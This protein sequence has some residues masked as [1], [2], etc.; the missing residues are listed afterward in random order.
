VTQTAEK[1]LVV[2]TTPQMEG[3][4]FHMRCSAVLCREH[5]KLNFTE[6]RYLL[7]LSWNE[8]LQDG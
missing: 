7:V 6:I 2:D 8:L 1:K 3:R 5:L 4:G